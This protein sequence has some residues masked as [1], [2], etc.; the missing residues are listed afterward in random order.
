MRHGGVHKAFVILRKGK[1]DI[2]Q[3]YGN[4]AVIGMNV[5]YLVVERPYGPPYTL[6]E[7]YPFVRGARVALGFPDILFG[8]SDAFK[9]ALRRL[10]AK[11]AELVLGLFRAHDIRIWDMV[12]TDRTGRVREL[13]IRPDKTASQLGW[14]FAVWTPEFTE[15]MHEYLA[16]PR[17][18]AEQPGGGLPTELTVG[19]VIQ[20]AVREGLV[21]QSVIF[22]RD[23]YLDI[24]TPEAL[25]RVAAGRFSPTND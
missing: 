13:L 4:G 24:G 25:Q 8:P 21:T 3:Y 1:W 15:F 5:G 9:R 23:D 7:A 14:V 11:K 16:V 18:A 19:E 22:P 17:T 12:V 20:A 6:D 2:P 10:Q